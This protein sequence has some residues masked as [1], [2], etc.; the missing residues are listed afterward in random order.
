MITLL[1]FKNITLEVSAETFRDNHHYGILS[2]YDEVP[3]KKKQANWII[4][5][6]HQIKQHVML[7]ESNA[8]LKKS[9]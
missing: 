7:H 3:Q 4:L 5:K 2:N 8:M 1:H 6:N 9:N